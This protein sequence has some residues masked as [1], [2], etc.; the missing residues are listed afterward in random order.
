MFHI[1]RALGRT[2][3]AENLVHAV[4]SCARQPDSARNREKAERL[5]ASDLSHRDADDAMR[6][7]TE[8][9][10]VARPKF[11]HGFGA[12]FDTVMLPS[13]QRSAPQAALAQQV[14]RI[15]RTGFGVDVPDHLR[16][17]A[18]Q[19]QALCDDTLFG[20][21]TTLSFAR[22]LSPTDL[23][24]M[25]DYQQTE[26]GMLAEKLGDII[27]TA[28]QNTSH[29]VS[30]E[31]GLAAQLGELALIT[32]KDIWLEATAVQKKN[33]IKALE[34][35]VSPNLA[36]QIL[37]WTRSTPSKNMLAAVRKVQTDL[38][39]AQ[40]YRHVRDEVAH[41]IHSADPTCHITF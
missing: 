38:D 24:A 19:V 6:R 4:E 3:S 10:H 9:I 21:E 32:S 14:V 29:A 33:I 13:L 40:C 12:Y 34:E 35:R 15:T 27:K 23:Q 16:S 30:T 41:I 31:P 1:K 39:M 28:A 11:G 22:H 26:A 17:A 25:A 18:N 36:E 20:R 5:F 2:S 37:N 8:L 7:A